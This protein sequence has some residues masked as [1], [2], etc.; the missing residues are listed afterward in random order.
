[1]DPRRPGLGGKPR[2]P[3]AAV[4]ARR[5]KLGR[6]KTHMATEDSALIRIPTL[7]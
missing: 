4:R 5:A 6:Q 2:D 7:L 3:L 1:V